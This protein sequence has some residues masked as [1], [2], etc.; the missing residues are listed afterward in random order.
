V[1]VYRAVYPWQDAAHR[2]IRYDNEFAGGSW[3]LVVERGVVAEIGPAR[4][5]IT[6]TEGYFEGRRRLMWAWYWVA[7]RPTTDAVRAKL[8]EVT[9]LLSGRRDAVAVAI[10]AECDRTCEG[11]RERIGSFL[12]GS[13][14]SLRWDPATRR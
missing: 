1:D 3:L 8:L 7:G 12:R 14:E 6:E 5:E 4:W 10:S 13:G 11:A 2:L 9:G